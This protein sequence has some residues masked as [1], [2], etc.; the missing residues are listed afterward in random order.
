MHLNLVLDAFKD[1]NSFKPISIFFSK[2]HVSLFD[3][4]LAQVTFNNVQK[5]A[6]LIKREA[7]EVS[8]TEMFKFI[9]FGFD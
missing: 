4:I 3:R 1:L 8:V 5:D 7:T 2:N 9:L 6:K